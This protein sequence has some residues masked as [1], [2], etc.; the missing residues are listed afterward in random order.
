MSGAV[1]VVGTGPGN[2]AYLAPAAKAA[3][4]QADV[5][6]G[7]HKYLKQIESL[8]KETPRIGNGM[9][10]EIE[11][12]QQA[13]DL[14][15]QA[16]IV[17][18]ISGGDAGIYGMAGLVLEMLNAAHLPDIPV[19]II[20][21][22]SALNAAAALL[23]APLMTDFVSISLSNYL[24]PLE[25]I[26]QRLTAA[27]KGDFVICLYNPRSHQRIEP[28]NRAMDLL[29]D[30]CGAQRLTG[31]V[32]AAYREEQ[33]VTISTLEEVQRMDIGMDTVLIIG[34]QSTYLCNGKMVTPRGYRIPNQSEDET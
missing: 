5:I 14:A 21:G 34:N 19:E 10:Y 23:G 16:K 15:Q 33:L 18:L 13:I 27:I 29:I 7:Y 17:A 3:I 1:F 4:E 31:V 30:S 8:A 2:L 12:A 22:I 24:T 11:R 20:P 25:K 28:F 9:R 32:K 26:E 6:L